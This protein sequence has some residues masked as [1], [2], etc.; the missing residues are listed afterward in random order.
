MIR[1]LLLLIAL[2]GSSGYHIMAKDGQSGDII[3]VEPDGVVTFAP[4]FPMNH[5][6]DA[7]GAGLPI[8]SVTYSGGA[9]RVTFIGTFDFWFAQNPAS[10]TNSL[11]TISELK[12]LIDQNHGGKPSWATNLEE[13]TVKFQGQ[14]ALDFS[15]NFNGLWRD[16]IIMYWRKTGRGI[17]NTI[18][19]IDVTAPN[20]EICQTLIK[21]VV[22][23]PPK[24]DDTKPRQQHGQK[25]EVQG[26]C[27]ATNSDHVATLVVQGYEADFF[28]LRI[29]GK[30]K[31]IK[32]NSIQGNYQ[33]E[34]NP[35]HPLMLTFLGE[36]AATFR[37][38]ADDLLSIAPPH[39]NYVA[40]RIM[41][42]GHYRLQFEYTLNSNGQTNSCKFDIH[43]TTKIAQ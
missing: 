11:T 4:P 34:T 22:V 28:I 36:E 37:P 10:M 39:Q 14:D 18:F 15:G 9:S 2:L 23:S 33:Y 41:K 40:R 1:R 13:K 42:D 38:P 27:T 32:I 7:G 21:A 26:V 3:T 35:A 5:Y 20:K 30:E 19:W 25:V 6:D 43:L 12:T 29:T 24:I 8:T 31:G 17:G 16:Q